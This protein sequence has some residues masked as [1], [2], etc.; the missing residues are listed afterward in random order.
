MFD[1]QKDLFAI[2]SA[3]LDMVAVGI[4]I[5]ALVNPAKQYKNNSIRKKNE[6][7][8]NAYE[9]LQC[10]VFSELN[11]LLNKYRDKN[12]KVCPGKLDYCSDD[13]E[14]FTSLLTHIDIFSAG[15]NSGIYNI[16]IVKSIGGKYLINRYKEL[17][18]LISKLNGYENLTK[19]V[20]DLG[21]EKKYVTPNSSC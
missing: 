8:I 10:E 1:I 7:T 5:A 17:Y 18:L 13:W 14:A 4:A 20:I 3:V 11:K 6:D 15:V 12:Q 9:K 2:V 16:E 19:L 21:I